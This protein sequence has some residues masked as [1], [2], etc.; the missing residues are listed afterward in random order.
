MGAMSEI[1]LLSLLNSRPMAHNFLGFGVTSLPSPLLIFPWCFSLLFWVDG[2]K[3]GSSNS[4]TKCGSFSSTNLQSLLPF[5]PFDWVLYCQKYFF[6]LPGLQSSINSSKDAVSEKF[7]SS[8]SSSLSVS[9]AL[10]NP[11]SSTVRK[12]V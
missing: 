10:L 1:F 3:T 7:I 9:I 6:L 12:T 2:S 11:S 5:G 8:S 4:C